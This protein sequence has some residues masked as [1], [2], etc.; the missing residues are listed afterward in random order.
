MCFLLFQLW[1][2][3]LREFTRGC[4][5][6]LRGKNKISNF[7]C[8]F[9]YSLSCWPLSILVS[10]VP[11]SGVPG[12]TPSQLCLICNQALQFKKPSLPA[13]HHQI[14]HAI[15]SSTEMAALVLLPVFE[16]QS[17]CYVLLS[18]WS[19]RSQQPTPHSLLFSRKILDLILTCMPLF[20][21]GIF[22]G[23]LL[24]LTSKMSPIS[25]TMRTLEVITKLSKARN[26]TAGCL[27]A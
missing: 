26:T 8:G 10:G 23:L 15:C 18:L 22:P 21:C 14:V 2:T 6:Y 4:C 25:V 11:V 5:F 9:S 12:N 3:A 24:T 20:L 1:K 27:S 13:Y 7:D 16:S 19:S 17:F